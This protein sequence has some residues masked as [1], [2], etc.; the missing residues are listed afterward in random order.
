MALNQLGLGLMFTA[1]DLASGVMGKV[2]NGFAQTRNELGQFGNRSQAAFQQFA[3]GAAMTTAGITGLAAFGMAV[4][5]AGEFESRIAEIRTIVP[6]TTLA[7]EDLTNNLHNMAAKFGDPAP[8]QAAAF[9]QVLGSGI[10][11]VAKA[12][13]ILEVSNKLAVGGFTDIKTSTDAVLR[14]LNAYTAQGLKAGDAADAL[15]KAVD[16]GMLRFEEI[17]PQIGRIAPNAA[18]AGMSFDELAASI[19][20]AAQ[21]QT[22]EQAVEGL[23]SALR[24]ILNPTKEAMDEAKRLGIEVGPEAIKAAGGM[25]Q[26]FDKMTRSSGY[27][28]ESLQKLISD[29]TGQTTASI[30]LADESKALTKALEEMGDKTG[31]VDKKFKIADD[32]FEQSAKKLKASMIS[33]LI[34]LGEALMPAVKMLTAFINKMVTGFNSLPKPVKNAIA[35][36][37]ALAAVLL[38]VAGAVT[39]AIAGAKILAAAMAPVAAGASSMSLALIPI[40][41]AIAAVVSAIAAFKIAIENNVGGLATKFDGI[42]EPI[43][44]AWEALTQL[45]TTGTLDE[46]LTQELINGDNKAVNFAVKIKQTADSILNFFKGLASGFET[47]I[48]AA[49]PTFKAFGNALDALGEA[50]GG[51]VGPVSEVD[52]SFGEAGASGASVGGVLAKLATIVVDGLTIAIGIVTGFVQVWNLVSDA[53]SDVWDAFSEVG[54]ALGSLISEVSGGTG[55]ASSHASVWQTV[56]NVLGGTVSVAFRLVASSISFV[57]SILSNLATVA[58]GVVKFFKG[59][60][61]LN[62]GMAF[63]G[64]G[65]IVAGVVNNIIDMVLGMVQFLADAAD[66]VGKAFGQDLGAG[67]ALKGFRDDAKNFVKGAFGVAHSEKV[68]EPP[69]TAGTMFNQSSTFGMGGP[70]PAVAAAGAGPTSADWSVASTAAASAAAKQAMSSLPPTQVNATMMVDGEVLGR[71]TA[72]A[73]ASEASRSGGATGVDVGDPTSFYR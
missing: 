31:L 62:M 51:L 22:T 47:A 20:V 46:A 5:H 34:S 28:S 4:K 54:T 21:V 42:I 8:L 63:E 55:A 67:K 25:K 64:L 16:I 41:L 38:T 19:G 48:K 68:V 37:G 29:S 14:S 56:G 27:T 61:T 33:A 53:L 70:S 49:E 57:A 1:T 35:T 2:R 71:L 3:K 45:F 66:A 12:N 40:G 60:F 18:R 13:D 73:N 58:G 26:W 65:Q 44:T 9:Y 50:F 6:E 72:K 52:A 39:M 11:D 32:T 17:G 59:V 36:A 30:L 7:T 43:K 10:T 15:A 69:P 23:N 24:N